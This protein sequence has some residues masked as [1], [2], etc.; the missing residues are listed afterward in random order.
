MNR[1]Q[2]FDTHA[3]KWDSYVPKNLVKK[4]ENKVLPFFKIKKSDKILDVGSGTGILLPILKKKAGKYG[5]ITA[6]DY[7]GKMLEQARK[8][9][10]NSFR[11]IRANAKKTPFRNN[12]FDKV[13]CFSVFPHFVNKKRLLKEVY[14][15]L[16]KNGRLVIAHADTREAI[17]L[18]HSQI[19]GPVHMDF[20]F[21]NDKM[22]GLLKQSG[23]NEI[24][25]KEGRNYYAAV[26]IKK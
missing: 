24:V 21:D 4:I 26:A 18:R 1:K 2:F 12:Y 7:S 5:E 14:R 11:Y 6:L 17:N 10:G 3:E 16:K 15:I 8:K 19:K 23:F 22:K 25:I 9:F 20:M 13:I